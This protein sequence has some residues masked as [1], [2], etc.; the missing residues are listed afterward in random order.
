MLKL[1]Y[2]KE[3]VILR[4]LF[5]VVQELETFILEQ[6]TQGTKTPHAPRP[7]EFEY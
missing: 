1:E 4:W 2:M 3:V 7:A 5:S 6:L